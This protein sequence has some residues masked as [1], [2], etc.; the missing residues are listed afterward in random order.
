MSIKLVAVTACI[1]G[2]A[3]TYMAAERLEKLCA[4]EKWSLKVETQGALGVENRLSAEDIAQADVVL[5]IADIM[6]EEA[7]RFAHQRGVEVSIH[8]FLSGSGRVISAVRKVATSPQE[9]R[10]RLE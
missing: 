1:S 3:H 7:E 8:G 6:L 5:L 10:I 2:V 9:T 4:Q